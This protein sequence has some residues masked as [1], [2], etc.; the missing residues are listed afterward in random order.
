[1]RRTLSLTLVLW[2]IAV[3]AAISLTM[4]RTYDLATRTVSV[5]PSGGDDKRV[6]AA[7]PGRCAWPTVDAVRLTA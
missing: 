4:A 7:P 5:A 3:L 6:I 2:T 1:M